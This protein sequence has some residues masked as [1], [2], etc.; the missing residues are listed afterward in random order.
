MARGLRTAL[1]KIWSAVLTQWK[2]VEPS[3]H[4]AVKAAIIATSS[5]TERKLPRRMASRL[6]MPNQVSIWFIHDADVGVKWKLTLGW[7]SSHSR[8]AGVLWEL[9]L[10]STTARSPCG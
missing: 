2:G 8:T 4:L 9:T 7:A 10:S 1:A 6:R 3:F 5:L